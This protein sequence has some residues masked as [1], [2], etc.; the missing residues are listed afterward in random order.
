MPGSL[1]W[2]GDTCGPCFDRR[3]DG[4]TP[5][6]G[7]GQF[8]GWSQYASQFT[9]TADS[10]HL[11][12][13][14][15]TGAFWKVDRADDTATTLKRKTTNLVAATGRGDAGIVLA[16]S[17]SGVFRWRADR[18]EVEQLLPSR[19]MWG[20]V[21]V[22]PDGSRITVFNYQQTLTANLTA[23]QPKY[24]TRATTT[25]YFAV[26]YA[27]NGS[28]LLG[29]NN[30]GE[31]CAV[32]PDTMASTVL[33]RDAFDGLPNGYGPPTELVVAADGESVLVRR[34]SYLARG[35]TAIRHVPL[36]GG[37]VVE[38]RVP[39]WHKPAA[40]AYAPDGQHA[41][42]AEA[43]GG[44][45]GF[46]ELANGKSLGFVRAVLEDTAWR[47]GQVEFAPDG[48]ALAVS[49]NTGHGTHGS[50]VAVWPWPTRW[51]RPPSR[52]GRKSVLRQAPA[53]LR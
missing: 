4:G 33:R 35:R 18:D 34:D 14:N 51:R 25:F 41:V 49:Y 27:P 36:A 43:E 45:V 19:H 6:G 46:W 29:A 22:P 9:F 7:F 42:T 20:R 53:R 13:K 16:M 30:Q 11:V 38:L 21:A 40:I 52:T 32:H 5:A 23:P 37:K 8:G 17:D 12:G 3:A 47:G 50:T 2:M 1:G 26:Q 44:W 10:R 24:A 31:I 28:R 39:D 48:R 15:R